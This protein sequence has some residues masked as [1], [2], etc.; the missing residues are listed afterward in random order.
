MRLIQWQVKYNSSTVVVSSWGNF[1]GASIKK[2]L[3]RYMLPKLSPMTCQDPSPVITERLPWLLRS[4]AISC[5]AVSPRLFSDCKA[6]ASSARLRSGYAQFST[7]P[8]SSHCRSPRLH[9]CGTR[10]WINNWRHITACH[11][12][13]TKYR[14]QRQ[15]TWRRK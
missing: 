10:V 1:Y 3:N 4:W 14:Q 15:K 9:A 11:F 13:L 6:Q 2:I 8:S 5:W 12:F 7:A